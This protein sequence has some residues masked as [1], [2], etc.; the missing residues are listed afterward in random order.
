MS[1]DMALAVQAGKRRLAAL[2]LRMHMY[3]HVHMAKFNAPS[4]VET[5][6]S[7]SQQ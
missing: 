4:G 2:L 6:L 1:P 5:L 7:V 3:E